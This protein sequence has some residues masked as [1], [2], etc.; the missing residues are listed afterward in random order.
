MIFSPHNT[1]SNNTS[2]I[3]PSTTSNNGLQNYVSPSIPGINFNPFLFA[4]LQA[5]MDPN[6]LRVFA[7]IQNA[8]L[9]NLQYNE[10]LRNISANSEYQRNLLQT[11]VML[12]QGNLSLPVPT[13]SST[14]K[15]ASDKFD[16]T[17]IANNI[18]DNKITG[19]PETSFSSTNHSSPEGVQSTITPIPWFIR[20]DVPG[21]SGRSYRQKKEFICE[22]CNRQF[23]KSYNLLIHTR[24]HTGIRPYPCDKCSKAFKRKDHLRDHMY[25]H[26]PTD[27]KPFV[28]EF[29]SKGFTQR[30]SYE[31]HKLT[32]ENDKI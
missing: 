8:P 30:R 1:N 4:S 19:S 27:H 21:N 17:N 20:K 29:C 2:S 31:A 11:S 10:F 9:L 22:Y 26:L 23:T 14:T 15:K 25:T 5:Q 16:F 18:T 24:T 12:S 28:C 7:A 3:F 6:F 13:N 32:H